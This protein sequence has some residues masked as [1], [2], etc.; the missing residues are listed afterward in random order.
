MEHE[1][2]GTSN[3]I[4][5]RLAAI[6]TFYGSQ[7]TCFHFFFFSFSFFFLGIYSSICGLFLFVSHSQFWFSWRYQLPEFSKDYHVVAIDM[8]GYGETDRP[9]NKD[10]YKLDLLTQDIVELIPALGYSNC[11]LVSHDWGG[12]VAW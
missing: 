3:L 9:P 4:H 5:Y 10:D 1:N 8:R 11:I 7:G 12:V 2:V 6:C